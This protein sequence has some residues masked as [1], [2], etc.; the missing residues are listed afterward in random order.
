MDPSICSIHQGGL[1]CSAV[2]HLPL[3]SDS[4]WMKCKTC[5]MQMH[6][7]SLIAFREM[8]MMIVRYDSSKPNVSRPLQDQH[9]IQTIVEDYHLFEGKWNERSLAANP[10]YIYIY[11]WP[12]LM[13][14]SFF[15]SLLCLLLSETNNMLPDLR[16]LGNRTSPMYPER[17]P[18]PL[19][20]GMGEVDTG[21]S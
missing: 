19:M 8:V 9:Y 7:V 20:E 15:D 12:W 5:A 18:A 21:T 11:I 13:I 6:R 10:P 3:R 17:G 4:L 16:A 1:Y 2:T 14:L